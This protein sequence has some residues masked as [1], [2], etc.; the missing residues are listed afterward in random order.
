MELKG[1]CKDRRRIATTDIY[2]YKFEY[3]LF[4]IYEDYMI[5]FGVSSTEEEARSVIKELSIRH[6]KP[7]FNLQQDKFKLFG[8]GKKYWQEVNYAHP[9]ITQFLD[10]HDIDMDYLKGYNLPNNLAYS[11]FHEITG[12]EAEYWSILDESPPEY[13]PIF[14]LTDGRIVTAVSRS[15]K[16]S[17]TFSQEGLEGYTLLQLVNYLNDNGL[18]ISEDIKMELGEA[19]GRKGRRAY[20]LTITLENKDH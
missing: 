11:G 7:V 12:E 17:Y 8:I 9:F 19:D 5:K 14:S 13:A 15:E 16:V 6:D 20:K 3:F 18:K 4:A 1:Y 2:E 10:Q